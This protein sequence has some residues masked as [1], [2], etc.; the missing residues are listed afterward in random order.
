MN[1]NAKAS[2]RRTQVS[3]TERRVICV[4]LSKNHFAVH[5]FRADGE[6]LSATQ[7][8]RSKF[9]RLVRD[10]Q[11]PRALWVMESCGTSQGWGALLR[12]LGDEVKLVPPQFVA[13]LR[14]GNKNDANDADTI[15]EVHRNPRVRAV[16]VK[17]EAQRDD[18]ATHSLRALLVRHRTALR[19]ALRG[20]L[21]ER[22]LIAPKGAGGL[23]ALLAQIDEVEEVD[24]PADA[25]P[26]ITPALRKVLKVARDHLEQIDLA[27][28]PL[29]QEI[30]AHVRRTPKAL[31]LKGVP[32]IGVISASAL[33]AEY[34]GGVGRFRDCR[35]FAANIGL[36]P[37]EHSSGGKQHLGPVTRHGN[38]YLRQLLIQG[39]QA[40]VR[41]AA[42]Y[43]ERP[44]P[45]DLVYRAHQM[46]KTKPR[47]VVVVA[48]ANRMARI[49]FSLLARAAPY[50]PLRAPP[51]KPAE[52]A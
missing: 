26:A 12:C 22:L 32:G 9:E 18:L 13:K 19:N 14:I 8:C 52:A 25:H 10:T 47:N 30:R 23:A 37:G 17:T 34:A 4:D 33:S 1:R 35:Q 46:L 36:A 16:P 7:M 28:A 31:A 5:Q 29:D 6:R 21:A 42:A 3:G 49:A 24:V 40:V 11:R 27:I 2:V 38:V 39:A 50:R 51:P 45:D 48:V 20:M 44:R 15:F 41:I 43:D